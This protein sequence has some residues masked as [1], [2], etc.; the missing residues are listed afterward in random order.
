VDVDAKTDANENPSVHGNLHKPAGEIR[1]A[2]VT[3][4]LASGKAACRPSTISA[5]NP[6]RSGSGEASNPCPRVSAASRGWLRLKSFR[7]G[8]TGREGGSSGGTSETN[9]FPVDPR[10]DANHAH[11]QR[12]RRWIHR[13]TF[14]GDPPGIATKARRG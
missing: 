10:A 3:R 9:H 2:L 1:P 11:D 12:E 8:Q 7:P 13:A 14:L 5:T 6:N 4:D